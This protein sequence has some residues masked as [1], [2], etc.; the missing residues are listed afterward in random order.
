MTPPLKSTVL[1][2]APALAVKRSPNGERPQTAEERRRAQRVL[3]RMQI[4]VHLP[5]K[6]KPLHGVTHTVSANGA[7][8]ILPEGLSQGTRLTIENEKTQKKVE[9]HVV[10]PPQINAEGSLIPLEFMAPNPNFWNIFFPPV[11]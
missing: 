7:M 6:A 2:S 1:A 11:N 5:G 9:A 3:L 4:L 8:I 10:R